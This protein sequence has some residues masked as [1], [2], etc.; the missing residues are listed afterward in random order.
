MQGA[1][2]PLAQSPLNA[3][4]QHMEAD[5]FAQTADSIRSWGGHYP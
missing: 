5:E 2:V 1:T 3:S 4:F